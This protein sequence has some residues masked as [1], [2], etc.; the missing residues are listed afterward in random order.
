MQTVALK[1][2]D[3]VTVTRGQRRHRILFDAGVTPD[4]L[5]KNMRRLGLRRATSR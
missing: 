5:V 1:P 3:A 4:G 2:V